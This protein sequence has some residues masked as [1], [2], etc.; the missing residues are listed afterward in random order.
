[1]YDDKNNVHYD[2][3]DYLDNDNNIQQYEPDSDMDFIEFKKI[4]KSEWENRNQ[5]END[6]YNKYNKKNIKNEKNKQKS[7][8]CYLS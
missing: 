6:K 3:F 8:N 7:C 4:I 5:K 2:Y 1:M